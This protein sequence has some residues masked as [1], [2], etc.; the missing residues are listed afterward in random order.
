MK[1]NRDSSA[2]HRVALARELRDVVLARLAAGAPVR[3]VCEE[4]S[5]TLDTLRAEVERRGERE[6]A[7]RHRPGGAS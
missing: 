7:P 3:V 4:L 2:R 6:P 5:A 1:T